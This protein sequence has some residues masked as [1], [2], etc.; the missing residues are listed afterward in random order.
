MGFPRQEDWS[1]LPFLSPGNYPD[2]GMV[3][4][5]PVWQ[6]DSLPLSHLGSPFFYARD[7][8]KVLPALKLSAKNPAILGLVYREE[9]GRDSEERNLKG[10]LQKCMFLAQ[11]HFSGWHRIPGSD[12][13]SVQ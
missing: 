3:P 5:S 10:L 7:I 8:F 6:A 11:S 1:G 13:N 12:I 4:M 2:P 9:S